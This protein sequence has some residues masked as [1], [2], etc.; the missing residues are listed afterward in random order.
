MAREILKLT[1]PDATYIPHTPQK[2]LDTILPNSLFI[3]VTPVEDQWDEVLRSGGKI[4]DHHDSIKPLV[5]IY[6]PLYPQQV[7]FGYNDRLESG[8]VLAFKFTKE[9]IPNGFVNLSDEISKLV[10]V[11]DCF[12][13]D[14]PD[15][16][17]ARAFGYYIIMSGNEYD[18]GLPYGDNLKR[19]VKLGSMAENRNKTL[20]G[21]AIKRN[22]ADLK[23]A[24]LNISEPISDISRIIMDQDSDV[25]LVVSWHSRADEAGKLITRFSMRSNEKFDCALFARQMGGGGHTRAAGFDVSEV[26]NGLRVIVGKLME[27]NDENTI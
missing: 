20:A 14:H 17:M 7:H 12:K 8:A 13:K 10:A 1:L 21:Y 11:S 6:R 4:L 23:I 26:V 5:D 3:D 27:L 24:V 22:V 16:N 19:I 2:R 15:F 18:E 9:K 25:D